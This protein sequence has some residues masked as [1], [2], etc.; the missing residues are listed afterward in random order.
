MLPLRATVGPL[1]G[2]IDVGELTVYED[3]AGAAAGF[4]VGALVV[5]VVGRLLFVPGVTRVVSSRNR[6][7]PTLETATRTYTHALVVLAAGLAGL[8]GAGYGSL[9]TDSAL[10]IAAVTLV[11]GVAGQEVIG[12]LISGLFLVADPDFNVGDWIAWPNGEGV[13]EAVDFRVTR[14]R[15]VNNETISVPNTELTTNALV[16]PYGRERYRVTEQVDIAYADDVELALRE[17]VEVARADDRVLD[18]PQPTSRIIDFAESSVT[19]KAEFWVA[20]PM[21]V[22]LVDVRSQFRR[23]AKLRFDEVDLTLGPASG[24]ELSGSLNVDF[25]GERGPTTDLVGE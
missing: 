24:R 14:V 16:R 21:D 10:I 15:T 4:V 1:F 11:L 25:E 13:V 20:S 18:D 12:A 6:N 3:A 2:Q 9:L 7:N 17:L 5:Y 23:R 22:N 19:L 8:V